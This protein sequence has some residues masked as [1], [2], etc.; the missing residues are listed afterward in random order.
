MLQLVSTDVSHHAILVASINIRSKDREADVV[1]AP[2]EH[3]L[4]LVP[5]TLHRVLVVEA[6]DRD[7]SVDL[8]EGGTHE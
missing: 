1:V 8:E 5:Q 6:Y 3:F 4:E 2:A 7:I